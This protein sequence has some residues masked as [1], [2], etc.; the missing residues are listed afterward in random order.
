MK[1]LSF[2]LLMAAGFGSLI[3]SCHKPD[4]PSKKYC[5]I[6]TIEDIYNP[7]PFSSTGRITNYAY[8][9]KRWLDSLTVIPT[10]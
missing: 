3:V 5:Q 8:N 7:S 2:V 10:C 9:N 6:K 4:I 1:K